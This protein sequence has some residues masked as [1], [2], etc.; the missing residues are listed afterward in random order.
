MK[1]DTLLAAAKQYGTPS[2]LFDLDELRER[3]NVIRNLLGSSITLTYSVKANPFLIP[4]MRKET[5][6]LEVCSPGELHLCE[7][8]FQN[9]QKAM[10]SIVYSG[11]QKTVEDCRIGIHDGVGICTAESVLQMDHLEQ[12]ASEEEKTVNV[13]LRLNSGSQF[14]MSEEDLEYLLQHYQKYPHLIIIGIHYFAGTQR[15]NHEMHLQKEELQMLRQKILYWRNIYHLDLPILEYGP[16]LPVPVF[17]KDDFEHSMQP[18]EELST[19]LKEASEWCDLHVEMGRYFVQSCGYYLTRVMDTKSVSDK[20]YSITDGGIHQI[21]YVGQVMGMKVPVIRSL[22][23]EKKTESHDWTIC[24][25][26]CTTNDD[27]VRSVTMADLEPGDI[28]AFCNAGAYAV[29]EGI[30]LFLSRPLPNVILYDTECGYQ[31]VRKLT[32]TYPLNCPVQKG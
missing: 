7:Q 12:A 32:E 26:L 13:L 23:P 3:M 8:V 20:H 25:S 16:G 9:D 27:L 2:Y 14:G 22:S 17:V 29:T 10:H 4:A 5:D 11:V 15:K 18:L 31:V 19:A 1:D 24:G 28:L 21:T 6:L 30:S